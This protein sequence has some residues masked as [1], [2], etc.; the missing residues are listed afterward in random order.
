MT[1]DNRRLCTSR[2]SFSYWAAQPKHKA[3]CTA[4]PSPWPSIERAECS[5]SLKK[6]LSHAQWGSG[7]Y[8]A[9]NLIGMAALHP[10]PEYRRQ[11]V[12]LQETVKAT[13]SGLAPQ[14]HVLDDLGRKNILIALLVQIAKHPRIPLL[15]HTPAD[16]N[17]PAIKPLLHSLIHACP[18]LQPPSLQLSVRVWYAE[19]LHRSLARV[20]D[21]MSKHALNHNVLD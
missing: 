2:F 14:L 11:R 12:D 21:F 20:P 13:N 17:H 5:V 9:Q 19:R 7:Y 3:C 1:L 4:F 10:P 8:K 6:Y 18:L 15:P 16:Q